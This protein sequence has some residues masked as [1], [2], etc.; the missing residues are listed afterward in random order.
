MS[1]YLVID[2]SAHTSVAVTDANGTVHAEIT[3]ER[4]NDQTETLVSYIHQLLAQAGLEGKELAGIIVGTGPGPFTGLRVG[5]VAAR[6]LSYV[7]GV[8]LHGTMSLGALAE[9][10]RRELQPDAEY[11]IATDARRREVYWARFAADGKLLDGPHVSAAGE[12]PSLEVHGVGAG[13][14]AQELEEAGAKPVAVS[15]DWLTRAADLGPRALA[16][17]AEGA[18]LSDTAPR[19][20]RE[21]DAQVPQFMKQAKS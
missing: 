1:N 4:S 10:V 13:L 20:L 7:W 19:Y 12:L 21:S 18:D 9:R 2:T 14:Y 6:T 8:P 15:R 5:L 11:L 17:L 3:S 16:E